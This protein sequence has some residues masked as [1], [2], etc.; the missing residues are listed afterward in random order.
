MDAQ[1]AVRKSPAYAPNTTLLAYIVG[2]SIPLVVDGYWVL[3]T[4]YPD[5]A[6]VALRPLVLSAA[7]FGYLLSY[8]AAA[9]LYER[10][11]ARIISLLAVTLLIP[12][13]TASNPLN[14]LGGWAR[15][16]F[17]YVI[18]LMLCRA[19]RD[20]RVAAA[21]G[22][23]LIFSSVL[24]T[25]LVLFTYVQ[26]MGLTVPTYTSA[27]I[28]KGIAQEA[29]LS[30]NA[31]P[32][33]AVFSYILAMCLI[34]PNKVLYAAGAVV[35]LLSTVMTG[36]RAP[37]ATVIAVVA[38]LIALRLLRSK[39]PFTRL[40]SAMLIAGIALILAGAFY[41]LSFKTWSHITEGRWDVW[42]VA[43]Q[44]FLERPITGY[45][46]YSWRDDLASRLPGEYALTTKMTEMSAGG[47]HN[48]YLTLLAEEGLLGFGAAAALVW[49]LLKSSY[50]LAFARWRTWTGGSWALFASLFL[51]LRACVEV[52]GLFGYGQDPAD[53]LAFLAVAI[54]V[55]RFSI[56]EGALQAERRAKFATHNRLPRLA[57][58]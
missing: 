34:R 44:K 43:V 37:L 56:E 46:Y 52:P 21:L 29:D 9:S 47:Y 5:A 48:E 28:F 7:L 3:Y 26:F 41:T 32:F 30:M 31:V 11:A 40:I 20:R 13:L 2:A 10:K 17:V 12:S 55:S 14:A 58:A 23:S 57:P 49:F 15:I 54:I 33:A 42:S 36:S 1:C 38:A 19:L 53:Y 16:A 35:L 25:A 51:L 8:K 18:A 6:V 50:R 27:R 39:R 45:G 24:L 22:W 4:L